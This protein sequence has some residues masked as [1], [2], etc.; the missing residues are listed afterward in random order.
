METLSVLIACETHAGWGRLNG[1]LSF[2]GQ[3]LRL[4]YQT[5][6]GVLGVIKSQPQTVDIA[7]G[8][9]S[10]I[11]FRLGWFWLRPSI[12]LCLS[13]FAISAT[14]PGFERGRARFRVEF[15]DRHLARRLVD[16]ARFVRSEVLHTR[17][18]SELDQ[19]HINAQRISPGL[20]QRASELPPPP[21]VGL[22]RQREHEG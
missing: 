22:S 9:V 1:M 19:M 15:G 10:N 11:G 8:G 13:D 5:K 18:V 12:E 17:L 20:D 21:P 16:Q 2:D 7:L 3:R 6:D 4:T 14:L